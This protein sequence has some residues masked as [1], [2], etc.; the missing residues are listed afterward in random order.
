MRLLTFKSASSHGK[1]STIGPL[2]AICL[3]SLSQ[4]TFPLLFLR[5]LS[6]CWA[7]VSFSVGGS[8]VASAEYV[9]F[10]ISGFC[11][12]RESTFMEF[13]ALIA[14]LSVA[15]QMGHSTGGSMPLSQKKGIPTGDH[16]MVTAADCAMLC[17]PNL[18]D[19]DRL[20]FSQ[21]Q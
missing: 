8:Y 11:F 2:N 18:V 7:C 12:N 16:A 13:L 3:H 1:S 15:A 6:L 10:F 21:R 19:S 17:P 5:S 20:L 14:S 9:R 4:S